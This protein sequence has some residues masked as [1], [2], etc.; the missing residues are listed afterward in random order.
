MRKLLN[1]AIMDLKVKRNSLESKIFKDNLKSLII[2]NIDKFENEEVLKIIEKYNEKNYKDDNILK[3]SYDAFKNNIHRYSFDQINKILRL[4]NISQIKDI[5]FNISVFNYIIKRLDAITPSI[6]VNIFHNLVK[7]G[8]RDYKSINI[9]KDHFIKNIDKFNNLDLT[10]ILS[11]F[12]IL[13]EELLKKSTNSYTNENSNN[14]ICKDSLNSSDNNDIFTLILNKIKNDEYIHN[15]LSVVNSVLILNMLSRVNI[16][17]YEIF[18]FFT[19]KYFKNLKEKDL[20]PHHF[21]LLL[22][23]FAKCNIHINIMKYIIKYMNNDNFI[24]HLSYVNITNAVHY[25]AKF[26]YKNKHFLMNLK[27]KVIE[28][29]DD[30]PQREFSNIIWSLSKLKISDNYFYLVSF[31]KIKKIIDSLDMMSIAQILDAMRRRKNLVNKTDQNCN[32]KE[33]NL[34]N[35]I[36]NK[37]TD[38]FKKSTKIDNNL[39]NNNLENVVSTENE[40]N[41]EI[42]DINNNNLENAV[43]TENEYNKEISDKNN[44]YKEKNSEE[45]EEEIYEKNDNKDELSQNGLKQKID[46][47]KENKID[48]YNISEEY[49]K[50]ITDLLVKKYLEHIETCSLHVLTQVPFCCLQL[51][52]TNYDVYYKSLETLKKKRNYIS[53]LNLIYA[54]YFVRLFIEKQENNFQKLPRSLKCFAKDIMNC[55]N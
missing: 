5:Q 17:N 39:N 50:D 1:T 6:I 40:Y 20:E 49:E 33:N 3:C 52:Y 31:K 2:K 44:Y 32:L 12:T 42:G 24:N 21:T 36:N 53:T 22:N 54:K 35:D 7:S 38:Q 37:S 27:N 28:I 45:I 9:I 8:L 30:I 11:S 15:N 25:M 48:I 46:E 34:K 41:K 51:N 55:D 47:L 13:Q 10:I 43:S 23:S 29:I 26:N 16:C 18:K 4:Y 14:I 19:K